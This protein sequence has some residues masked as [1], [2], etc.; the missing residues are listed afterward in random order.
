MEGSHLLN[1]GHIREAGEKRLKKAQSLGGVQNN[2]V[3]QDASEGRHVV[4]SRVY[5][6][7]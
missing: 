2:S 6:T 7:S 4:Q 1:Q 3:T 5:I